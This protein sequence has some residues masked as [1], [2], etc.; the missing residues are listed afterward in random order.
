VARVCSGKTQVQVARDL[1]V[2]TWSLRR[3]VEQIEKGQQLNESRTL[4]VES[5]EQRKRG[6]GQKTTI[7]AAS[8][9]S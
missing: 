2:S 1:D 9:T 6:L 8:A 3:W 4:T 7:C 5:A